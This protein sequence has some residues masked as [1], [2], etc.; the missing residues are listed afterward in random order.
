MHIIVIAAIAVIV[1]YIYL[2]NQQRPPQTNDDSGSL[3]L[4]IDQAAGNSREFIFISKGKLFLKTNAGQIEQIHSPYVQEMIDR[5]ERKKQLHG[6][7]ENTTLNTSF[8]GQGES[9]AA[10]QVELQVVSAQFSADNKLIYFLKD[11][12]VGGL[13]EY[14]AATKSERRLLHKQNLCYENLIVN[15]DNGKILC[16]QTQ[17]NGI[18]NIVMLSEDGGNNRQLTEGDTVDSSPAW[19]P[20]EDTKILYQSSGLARSEDG[21]VIAYG[22]TSVKLLDIENNSVMSILDNPGF[23]FLQPRVDSKGDLYFIKRP[24]EAQN[25]GGANLLLDFL[26]FPFRLLRALFHYLN[27]FSLMYSRKPLTTAS[28]PKVNADIK[29]LLIKGKRIDAEKAMRKESRVNG[30]P[31]LVPKSWQLVKK[32]Q[33]GNETVLATNVASFDITSD[34]EILYSNGYAVFQ[35]EADSQSKVILRNKLIAD[36]VAS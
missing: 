8:T 13:F 26:F 11:S 32:T 22:P 36:I 19:I 15:R 25:Y 35:L 12:H 27:F 10:D 14:D 6:W 31:S 4:H 2:S 33:T 23:D 18:A 16:S 21:Y 1:I 20:G 30:V 34:D 17:A 9:L 5:M 7:K 24:Y 28:G 29:D 3:P